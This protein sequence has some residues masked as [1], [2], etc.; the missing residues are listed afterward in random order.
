MLH[1]MPSARA[2]DQLF[3]RLHRVLHPGGAFV[4]VDSLDTER[5]RQAHLDDTFVPLDPATLGPRLQAAGFID[6]DLA[7]AGRYRDQGDQIR[8]VARKPR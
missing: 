2:Q 8:F 1:H 6:I 5:I 3:A 7:Q 4:A